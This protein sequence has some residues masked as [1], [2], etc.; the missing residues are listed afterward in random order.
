MTLKLQSSSRLSMIVMTGSC[1]GD[2]D[3]KV[4]CLM[5]A[6]GCVAMFCFDMLATA[7]IA[8]ETVVLPQYLYVVGH[9]VP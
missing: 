9:V 1:E 4:S 5:L 2:A 6:F 8:R 7:Y 3:A